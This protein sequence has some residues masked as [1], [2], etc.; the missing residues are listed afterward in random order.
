MKYLMK[1][2]FVCALFTGGAT[3]TGGCTA[4]DSNARNAQADANPYAGGNGAFGEDP[5]SP[6]QYAS[7]HVGHEQ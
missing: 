6:G 5:V 3:L 2:L 4:T 7:A 1:C